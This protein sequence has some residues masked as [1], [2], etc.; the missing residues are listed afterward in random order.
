MN[1]VSET[2]V[3]D[4]GSNE[5]TVTDVAPNTEILEAVYGKVLA[6]YYQDSVLML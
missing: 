1:E 2:G 4:E 6:L 3:L 5:L